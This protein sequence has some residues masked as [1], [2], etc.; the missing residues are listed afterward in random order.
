MNEVI[1]FLEEEINENI[2]QLI[3][4]AEEFGPP[5]RLEAAKARLAEFQ[6]AITLLRKES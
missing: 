4:H 1:A 6:E 3:A 5:A 2:L